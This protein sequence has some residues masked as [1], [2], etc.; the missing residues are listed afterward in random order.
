MDES[1]P[2]PNNNVS[3]IVLFFVFLAG[4]GSVLGY[5]YVQT[6]NHAP[7]KLVTVNSSQPTPEP[8]FSLQPPAQAVSGSLT[9]LRGHTEVFAREADAYAEA[10]TGATILVGESVATKENASAAI[11]IP[12]IL[13]TTLEQKAEVA[14]ANLYA[15]N[16]VLQQ[17]SGTV[18]YAHLGGSSPIAIR[19][20][21]ALVSLRSGEAVINIFDTDVSVTVK[22][23]TVK[24]ALVDLQNNTHVW[25]LAEGDRARID[26]EKRSVSVSKAR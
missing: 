26:D 7:A 10:S 14:F 23:G 4:V 21:R 1:Q 15:S 18:T 8:T 3:M 13:K 11:E 19:A 9:V 20:L 5:R 2:T 12:N 16:M 24:L 22:T 25:D 17:K 6:I